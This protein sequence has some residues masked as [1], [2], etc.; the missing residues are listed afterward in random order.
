MRPRS[1][2]GESAAKA[3]T[4]ARIDT[5]DRRELLARIRQNRREIGPIDTSPE[6]VRELRDRG[7]P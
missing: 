2:K 5:A 4:S 3:A 7:R 6:T 1:V